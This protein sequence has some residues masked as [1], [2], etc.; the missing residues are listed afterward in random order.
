MNRLSK[1]VEIS[2]I[3]AKKEICPKN[4]P[5]AAFA[6]IEKWARIRAGIWSIE[7]YLDWCGFCY[8]V[9]DQ[10]GFNNLHHS[11]CDAMCSMVATGRCNKD[12]SLCG[13]IGKEYN[14]L[15]FIIDR[16][17]EFIDHA[18]QNHFYIIRAIDNMIKELQRIGEKNE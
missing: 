2:L 8:Y 16:N 15:L 1:K 13:K 11:M 7:K 5:D 9:L 3:P 12:D 17:L 10:C 6:S 4:I 18:D 14:V